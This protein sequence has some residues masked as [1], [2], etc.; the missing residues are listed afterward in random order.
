MPKNLPH[1]VQDNLEKCRSAA[2]AAVDAYNRPGPRFR[3]AQYL[4]MITIAWTALFHAIYFKRRKKPW[5]RTRNSGAGRAVRYQKID[6]EPRH[7]DLAE[8]LKQYYG[9]KNPAERKNLEFLGRLRNKIEHRHLPELDAS[10][11]GE[12]QA[13]LLNLEELLVKE[14]GAKYALTE[15]LAVSLQFSS[16][17]PPQKAQAAKRLVS[18]T[19]KSVTEYIEKF[20]GALPSTVLNSMKY[21]YSVFLVPKVA[22]R[23]SAADAAVVFVKVDEA[24]QE[25]LER[26]ERLNV[27]IKEKHIPIANIDLYKPGQVVAE[28]Q[29]RVPFV[30]TM[31]THTAAW[32][33]FG[34][35]PR[36]GEQHPER[37][38]SEYCVFDPA[39]GDYLYTKVWIERLAEELS[40]PDRFKEI[41]GW[42]PQAK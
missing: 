3:T 5:Y 30:V 32:R 38:R 17:S 16:T 8:C 4:V 36:Y 22:N 7:W 12:C 21:S 40:N 28:L 35:R 23:E 18:A 11:Y 27:L 2:I 42:E 20:R 25:E 31:A 29:A 14:F 37:T 10:L 13:S 33:Q 39:H 34:V 41:T 6:G 26:V 9:D 15:S 1:T 24:S 19:A